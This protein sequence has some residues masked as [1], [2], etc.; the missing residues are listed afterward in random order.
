MH[1]QGPLSKHPGYLSQVIITCSSYHIPERHGAGLYLVIPRIRAGE[2]CGSRDNSKA[3]TAT[4]IAMSS[5]E[6]PG[7]RIS[8]FPFGVLI[9]SKLLSWRSNSGPS[10]NEIFCWVIS[11]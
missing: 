5:F 2:R 9:S 11:C 4:A 3:A 1:S 10:T 7:G 6:E 8:V